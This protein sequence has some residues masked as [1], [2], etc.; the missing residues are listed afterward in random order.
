MELSRRQIGSVLVLS[1]ESP[2]ELEGESSVRFKE[3][4]RSLVR[5]PATQVVLDL[6][7][8]T[9]VDSSGLGALISTL[10]F[11][12]AGGGDLKLANVTGPVQAVLQVTRLLR[13]FDTYDDAEEAAQAAG[14]AAVET[15]R[16][17]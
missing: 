1:F 7:H 17:F 9:F 13:V 10:K 3:R 2:L 8:L 11:L 16:A 4:I 15:S 6:G 12:R 14:N 5:D